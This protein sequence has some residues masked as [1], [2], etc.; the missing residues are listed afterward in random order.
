M[1]AL[2][3]IA[4]NVDSAGG[5]PAERDTACGL[6][7]ISVKKKAKKKLLENPEAKKIEGRFQFQSKFDFNQNE[8]RSHFYPHFQT[9]PLYLP[10]S[11]DNLHVQLLECQAC[12]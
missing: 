2:S 9:F 1:L 11:S 5:S 6:L 4:S 12:L 10:G 3:R 7:P 8:G